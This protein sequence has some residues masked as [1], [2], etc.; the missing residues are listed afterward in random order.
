M[1]AQGKMPL[2]K[3]PVAESVPA[4]VPVTNKVPPAFRVRA[5]RATEE[6]LESV[7]CPATMVVCP[8]TPD[9]PSAQAATTNPTEESLGSAEMAECRRAL[10][11]RED[12]LGFMFRDNWG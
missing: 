8:K 9:D 4:P 5:P 7:F 1:A 12:V 3:V 10:A 11:R 6:L 2:V